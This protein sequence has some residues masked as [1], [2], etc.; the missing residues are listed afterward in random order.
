LLLAYVLDNEKEACMVVKD[1]N[2]NWKYCWAT[3]TI[4]KAL[5]SV[6]YWNQGCWEA[7]HQ[8]RTEQHQ[9]Y[10]CEPPFESPTRSRRGETTQSSLVEWKVLLGSQS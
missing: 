5:T 2:D 10:S 4:T 3:T 8:K 9:M 6:Y 1:G 7:S